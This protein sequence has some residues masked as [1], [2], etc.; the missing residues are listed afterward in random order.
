MVHLRVV[1][2]MNDF[3][4]TPRWD[5]VESN[6]A[7]L[8]RLVELEVHVLRLLH[9]EHVHRVLGLVS[10]VRTLCMAKLDPFPEGPKHL[11]VHFF[12]G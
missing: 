6:D 11:V 3:H 2:D 1:V 7:A 4:Q 10:C 12:C 5:R 9:V 8:Q